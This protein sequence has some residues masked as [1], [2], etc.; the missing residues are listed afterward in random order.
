MTIT[1]RVTNLRVE[2]AWYPFALNGINTNNSRF[3]IDNC[4]VTNFFGWAFGI[5]GALG[6][7]DHNFVYGQGQVPLAYIAH[8]NWGG[9]LYSDGSHTAT[10]L[11]GT[12]QFFFFED[13]YVT[14]SF[15]S[16]VTGADGHFGARV[17]YRNN[18]FHKMSLEVHGPEVG[19]NRGGRVTEVYR[20]TFAGD[21]SS[22]IVGY[23]R[24]GTGLVWSNS[25]VGFTDTSNSLFLIYDV[26]H[27]TALRYSA[28]GAERGGADGINP[29]MSN[30][31]G[32]PFFSGTA[33][34]YVVNG[35]YITVTNNASTMVANEFIGYAINRTSGKS[36]TSITK[37]AGGPW[38][39]VVCTGHGF[40]NGQRVTVKG[41]TVGGW[42]SLYAI[43]NIDAN[44]FTFPME[45]PYNF[46]SPAAGTIIAMPGMWF[47]TIVS[48]S[49]STITYMVSGHTVPGDNYD[50][51]LPNTETF[52]IYRTKYG[53]DQ[54]GRVMGSSIAATDPATV[55]AAWND[56]INSPWYAWGNN[57]ESGEL[58]WS[59]S[60]AHIV[61][62]EHYTNAVYSYTPF[63]YPHPLIASTELNTTTSITNA[64]VQGKI[65]IE[66]KVLI[67]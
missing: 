57:Y 2:D 56:Q 14:N 46:T 51:I 31:V 12:D 65:S 23:W 45:Y 41:A 20:N 66:G 52:E 39:T 64:S 33:L 63:T 60:Y 16:R 58:V 50:L 11:Y 35:N 21:N 9:F 37:D 24:S 25:I 43:T 13:N 34:G 17:V 67:Q 19:Y 7:V 32:G 47:S 27:A 61:G 36:V 59:T 28:G 4:L 29:W 18:T 42:N 48:N 5:N 53:M 1:S 54:P 3:R 49:T 62:G 15:G 38:A 40:T 44:T 26:A 30:V 6:V 8:P 55:P 10:N 22:P